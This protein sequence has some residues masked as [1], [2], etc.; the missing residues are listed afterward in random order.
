MAEHTPT[1][2]RVGPETDRDRITRMILAF[3]GRE[4][5]T[6]KITE[7]L[8]WEMVEVLGACHAVLSGEPT[9]MSMIDHVAEE[10]RA[11]LAKLEE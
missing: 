1:D 5:A 6:E 3:S 4:I 9:E 7:G 10:A 11:L 2:W 8:F